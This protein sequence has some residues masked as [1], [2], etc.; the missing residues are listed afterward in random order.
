VTSLRTLRAAAALPLVFTALGAAAAHAQA[1]LT[2]NTLRL[3]AGAP[4]PA[5]TVEDVAWI[6]GHWQGA[7][8]GGI[9]EEVW[10]PPLAGTTMGMFRLVRGGE[11]SFYE[12]LTLSA[13]GPSLVLTL[14]HFHPDLRGWE[15]R[16]ETVT[17]PL[18]RLA[19]G[20]AAFAGM[21]FRRDGDETLRVYV[22]MGGSEAPREAEFVFNRIGSEAH[23]RWSGGP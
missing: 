9:A 3:E 20:E 10:A 15:E 1:P 12:I 17:F 2:A 18:V 14:R 13:D 16:D 11:V 5:A 23:R 7:A 4:R 22:A 21:T 19:E 6:A 8:L